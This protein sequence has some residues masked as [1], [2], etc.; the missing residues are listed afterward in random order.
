MQGLILNTL[1][2]LQGMG[3]E[4]GDCRIIRR[5]TQEIVVKNK[6]PEVVKSQESYG[7]GIRVLVDGAWGFAAT[8]ELDA[9]SVNQTARIAVAVARAST[10]LPACVKEQLAPNTPV[11]DSYTTPY[12][13]DPF[14]IS[15]ED[16]LNVLI[17]ATQQMLKHR[18]VKI[19]RSFFNAMKEEKIFGSTEGAL[20][21]QT[22]LWCGGGIVAFAI[23]NGEVQ[24]RSYPSSF[25][26]N[27]NTGGWEFFESLDLVGHADQTA[28][29][30]VQLLKSPP[31]PADVT[32]II[33]TDDQLALQVHESIG[34]AIELDRVFGSEVSLAGTSFLS[35]EMRGSFRYG[36]PVV[37]VFADATAPG[38]LGTFGYDDE[39]VPAQRIPIIKEGIFQGFLTSRATAL[40][41]G[42]THSNGTMRADGWQ[43]F[44]LIRMTNINLEPAEPQAGWD[45]EEL[46]ADTKKGLLLLTNK[47][48]SI[49]DRRVNFQFSTE[50]AREIN[51]GKLGR[52]YKNPIYTGITWEFWRSCDAVCSRKWW[53]MWGTPNCGK[54]DPMQTMFVGHG[55]APARFRNIQVG[56]S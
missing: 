15:L 16:K 32:T 44:P 51:N 8:N 4:Y 28:E 12:Q 53:K 1:S 27:F 33:L 2:T 42:E 14:D 49:D 30:A 46:I 25:R 43:N 3:I 45:F 26:G 17:Q 41:I 7:I 48:W 9:R 39:G 40:R 35:P 22:I 54:G 13:V 10:R 18:K 36:S 50:V 23:D 52:M 5:I 20:I 11:K 24:H 21:D 47:S 38:G 56:S 31:C 34:H 37:N 29:E 55:V 6:S 19:A